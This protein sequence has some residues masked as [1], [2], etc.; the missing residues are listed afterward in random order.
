M[1]GVEVYLAVWVCQRRPLCP[2]IVPSLRDVFSAVM[3]ELH[4]P[5]CARASRGCGR[6]HVRADV[7]QDV[8][9]PQCCCCAARRGCGATRL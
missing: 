7:S 1:D 6:V 9:L 8:L 2:A 3:V 4:V 5:V